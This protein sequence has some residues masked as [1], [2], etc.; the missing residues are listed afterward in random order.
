[1][2][3]HWNLVE[4]SNLSAE[5]IMAKDIDLLSQLN[6]N[7]PLILHLYEWQ[8]PALTYGYFIQPSDFLYLEEIQKQGIQ[9]ARRPTGGG[10]VF[11]LTD[12]AFSILIPTHSPYL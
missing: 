12:F 4:S 10:I 3:S 11:H 9:I 2:A 1:M 6:A 8:A 7:S 5:A